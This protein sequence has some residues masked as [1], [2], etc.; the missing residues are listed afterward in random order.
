MIINIYIASAVKLINQL[1][2]ILGKDDLF[3]K[4]DYYH[5]FI[6]VFIQGVRLWLSFSHDL[7]YWTYV[8]LQIRLNI[9]IYELF[10]MLWTWKPILIACGSDIHD[11]ENIFIENHRFDH[12]AGAVDA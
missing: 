8:T 1:E 10:I 9:D 12:L 6:I 11:G 5:P 7:T 2:L 4:C 3:P